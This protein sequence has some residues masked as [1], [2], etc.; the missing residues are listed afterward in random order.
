[1]PST[2]RPASVVT[3]RSSPSVGRRVVVV[4]IAL[5]ASVGLAVGVDPFGLIANASE[6][7]VALGLTAT[8]AI[9]AFLLVY[10]LVGFVFDLVAAWRGS[11][12]LGSGGSADVGG[13]FGV[14]SSS[15]RG[16]DGWSVS[17]GLGSGG[18]GDPGG[19][20]GGG[21]DGSS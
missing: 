13:G 7:T 20:D 6:T 5:A 21:G 1:M 8:E 15:E 19:D 9:A 16:S 3:R 14:W 12:P 4:V 18:F 17:E 2:I 10:P 11:A